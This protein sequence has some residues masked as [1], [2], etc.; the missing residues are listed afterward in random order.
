MYTILRQFAEDGSRRYLVRNLEANPHLVELPGL[1]GVYRNK[2]HPDI[3]IQVLVQTGFK[4]KEQAELAVN[5]LIEIDK[6]CDIQSFRAGP[7]VAALRV[8]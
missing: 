4:S 3:E 5:M 7:S 2:V 1:S 8:A 6:M